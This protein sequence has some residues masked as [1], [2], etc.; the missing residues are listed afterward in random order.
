MNT[1][2]A[3]RCQSAGRGNFARLA[4]WWVITAAGCLFLG[5]TVMSAPAEPPAWQSELN[6]LRAS[7][8]VI[9]LLSPDRAAEADDARRRLDMLY[10]RLVARY[11]RESAVRK[12]AGDHYWRE[13]HVSNAI[14]EWEA[15]Q[16][17]DPTD[18]DTSSALGGARLHEGLPRAACQEFQ[19]AVAAQPRAARYHFELGNVLYVFRHQLT[20]LPDLPDENAVIR[21]ALVQLR[22]AQDLAGTNVEFARGYAETF[23]GVPDP[24]WREALDAWEHV[25][26]LTKEAPDFALSHLARV[27]LRLN[28]PDDAER[29]L[30]MIHDPKFSGLQAKLRQQASKL[31]R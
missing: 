17:L 8:T 13:D 25:R 28:R 21:E 12:A 30:D 26:V 5:A 7:E 9:A 22:E 15:A 6:T 23:Y 4:R 19:R 3:L 20:G 27:S 14:I 18:A 16:A 1:A 10:R 24:D 29:Y 2:A 31:R 11:P